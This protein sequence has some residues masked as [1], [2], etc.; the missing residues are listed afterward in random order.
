VEEGF[1]LMQ[2]GARLM[3]RG[4][5]EEMRPAL[6][7][8]GAMAGDMRERL[9]PALEMMAREMGPAL[10]AL[11]G[12]IDSIRYYEAP[13]ILDNGDIIIRRRPDAPPWVP[14]A[15]DPDDGGAPPPTAEEGGDGGDG[16]AG[17]DAESG[18]IDL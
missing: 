17:A 6:D 14:P 2:E 3:F 8:L 10:L 18:P 15:A 16:A 4:I 12:T 9:D 1:S 7:D 11:I 13:V 5:L